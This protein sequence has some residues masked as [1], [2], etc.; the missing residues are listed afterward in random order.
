MLYHL[1]IGLGLGG[2]EG[3]LF[4]GLGGR[5]ISGSGE[6]GRGRGGGGFGRG[7]ACT[8]GCITFSGS[9]TFKNIRF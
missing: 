7:L 5:T 2:G 8:C 1:L 6:T 3:S 9:S 4:G